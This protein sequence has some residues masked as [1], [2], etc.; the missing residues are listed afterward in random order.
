MPTVRV[1][2]EVILC[3]NVKHYSIVTTPVNELVG[4]GFQDPDA[5]GWIPQSIFA[6]VVPSLSS[7]LLGRVRV[8]DNRSF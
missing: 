4:E 7:M 6:V 8:G 5:A 2:L 3:Y 1:V